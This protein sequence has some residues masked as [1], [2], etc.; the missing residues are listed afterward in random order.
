MRENQIDSPVLKS[1][2]GAVVNKAAKMESEQW[3]PRAYL[4]EVESGSDRSA[5]LL[6]SA[7][8]EEEIGKLVLDRLEVFDEPWEKKLTGRGG[9]LSTFFMAAMMAEAMGV[10][11]SRD[12]EA[13]KIIRDI[14][15][16]SASGN[17][18]NGCDCHWVSQASAIRLCEAQRDQS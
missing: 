1:Q 18:R 9:P 6:L 12:A 8:L 13:I 17:L 4:G 2:S 3:N 14:R 5:A 15:T 16:L 11:S 7:S 10:I